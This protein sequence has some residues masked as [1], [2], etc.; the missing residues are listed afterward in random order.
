MLE[1]DARSRLLQLRRKPFTQLRDW[2]GEIESFW[3]DQLEAFKTHAERAP[4][5]RRT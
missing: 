5:K 3:T 4:K 1:D 2:V